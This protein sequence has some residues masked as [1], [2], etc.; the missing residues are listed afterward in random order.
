MGEKTIIPIL[1]PL[2]TMPNA[3]PLPLGNHLLTVDI[4][5]TPTLHKK[6][7]RLSIYG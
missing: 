1:G 6:L 4:E 5:L 7:Y 3:N 2:V